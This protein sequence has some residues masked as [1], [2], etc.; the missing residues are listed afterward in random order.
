M[1]VGPEWRDEEVQANVDG[2]GQY[3]SLAFA[4]GSVINFLIRIEC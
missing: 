4:E 2:G 1:E 3:L